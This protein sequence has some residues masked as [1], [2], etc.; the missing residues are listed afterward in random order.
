MAVTTTQYLITA[1]EEALT[2]VTGLPR[3]LTSTEIF[4]LGMPQGFPADIRVR[5][6]GVATNR[7]TC[8]VGLGERQRFPSQELHND[9]LWSISIWIS[10]DYWIGYEGSLYQPSG[11]ALA[12]VKRAFQTEADDCMRIAAALCYPGALTQTASA[13]STGLAGYALDGQSVRSRPRIESVPEGGKR[14]LSCLDTYTAR[15][16]FDPS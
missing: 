11:S 5:D 3:G 15:I 6:A 7:K 10:R 4:T 2:T 8:F 14:L 16:E 1:I 13:Q 9:H 12:E